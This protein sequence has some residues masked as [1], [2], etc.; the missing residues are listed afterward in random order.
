MELKIREREPA[1]LD[2]AFT[3]AVRLE[4][5]QQAY[6]EDESKDFKELRPS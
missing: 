6:V 1:D 4:M 2:T 5:Y 3:I